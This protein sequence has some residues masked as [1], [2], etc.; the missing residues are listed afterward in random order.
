[1]AERSAALGYAA[2]AKEATKGT[3]VTPTIYVPYYEQKIAT[4]PN[5]VADMPVYGGKYR[6]YQALQGQRSHKGT[7]KVM[8]EPNTTGYWL[9]MLLKRTNTTGAN[10]Y[11]HTFDHSADS[12][13]YTMDISLVSQV[14]RFF[15]VQASKLIPSFSGDEMQHDITVSA[16]GSFYG[17]EVA[18]VATTTV[19]LVTTH[20]PAPTTGLVVGDLVKVTKTDGSVSTNFTISSLTPTTVTLNATA[21]AF[22]AGDMLVLRPAT[23]SFSLLTP[24]LWPTTQFCFG[25][26][27]SAALSATQTRLESGSQIEINH[28]FEDD[29]GSK[30]SGSYD[31]ASLVRTVG[32]ASFKIKQYFD[33]PDQL[34]QWLA[35]AKNA[36]VMRAYSQGTTYE[37]R[38]TLNNLK[39]ATDAIETKFGDV[40]YQEEDY[41]SVYDS[42]DATG[43]TA[44]VINGI[45][46]I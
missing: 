8:A 41:T 32:D 3:A 30:R 12:N 13:S 29:N 21:A 23:P 26:T 36:C 25:A 18:S 43:M 42:S 20:D 34:K 35:T 33:N 22:A 15:G 27:A 45:S 40:I 37:F 17:A 39:I 2:L 7:I 14:V 24:F 16:L 11:T 28:D 44:V 9:D 4:D 1:M 5:L 38:V 46:S 31:P 10:P 6:T 19:T